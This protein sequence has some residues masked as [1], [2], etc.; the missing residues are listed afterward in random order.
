M[1][2]NCMFI[3]W[4]LYALT[5]WLF[6]ILLLVTVFAFVYAYTAVLL[7]ISSIMYVNNNN[8][9]NN[10]IIASC[11]YLTSLSTDSLTIII[12]IL[13]QFIQSLTGR[14]LFIEGKGKEQRFV[15]TNRY[16]SVSRQPLIPYSIRR[17]YHITSYLLY[18]YN[19]LLGLGSS[20]GRTV[21]AAGQGLVLAPR[22]DITGIKKSKIDKGMYCK[23]KFTTIHEYVCIFI[24][25]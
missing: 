25:Y 16:C 12:N 22:L 13:I 1:N 21:I 5:V 4:I 14:F 6:G 2:I 8:N 11:L 15:L 19:G 20:I 23:L 17:L 24:A 9:N 7:I 18:C 10:I 3:G